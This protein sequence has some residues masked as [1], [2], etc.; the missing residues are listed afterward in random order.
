MLMTNMA[1]TKSGRDN[2]TLC[3]LRSAKRMPPTAAA[4][5]RRIA[6]SSS[7]TPLSQTQL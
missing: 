1:V 7:A 5:V 6:I 4:A 2:R 3:P